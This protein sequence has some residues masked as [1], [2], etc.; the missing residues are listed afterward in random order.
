[1]SNYLHVQCSSIAW[2]TKIWHQRSIILDLTLS[3][4]QD[5]N[6][7]VIMQL[8]QVHHL[9]KKIYDLTWWCHHSW[10]CKH[11]FTSLIRAFKGNPGADI[12]SVLHSA[13]ILLQ[14]DNYYFSVTQTPPC[15]RIGRVNKGDCAASACLSEGCQKVGRN[16]AA[17]L[18]LKH[19]LLSL[20]LRR[21]VLNMFILHQ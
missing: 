4:S 9:C 1:M 2:L 14:V 13:V 17:H 10:I 19:K 20:A 11:T 15:H 3:I 6:R 18:F 5:C 7:V 12:T 8:P 21:G 16:Q